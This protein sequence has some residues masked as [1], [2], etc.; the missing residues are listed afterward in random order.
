MGKCLGS[1]DGELS[2]FESG[3]ILFHLGERSAR[4]MPTEPKGRSEVIQ[5][6][7][8]ALNSVEMAA[9]PDVIFRFSG[10]T[11]GTPARSRR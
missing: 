3:A 6:V 7:F 1:K 11:G 5:W 2:I 8:A 9:L 10:D 4:L